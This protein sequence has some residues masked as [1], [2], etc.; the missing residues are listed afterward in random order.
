MSEARKFTDEQLGLIKRNAC[1]PGNRDATPDEFNLFMDRV[2]STGLNPLT[3]QIYAVFRWSNKERIDKMSIQTGIDGFRLIAERT[4]R[5]IGQSGPY[6]C[7]EDG[8]CREIWPKGQK[9]PVASKVVV[10]KLLGGV[11]GE[12]S[13]V[14]HWGEYAVTGS[15][16]KFW[17]SKPALLLSK[18]A[19]ALALRK[20]FPAEMS[21]LYIAEEMGDESVAPVDLSDRQQDLDRATDKQLPKL[22]GLITREKP[23]T[24]TLKAKLHD[25]GAG[26]L[27]PEKSGW[28]KQLTVR[29]AW[30][31]IKSL[32][33]PFQ[34]PGTTDIPA[35]AGDATD[36]FPFPTPEEAKAV[37]AAST[38]G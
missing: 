38:E 36:A 35:D 37:L 21:G 13:A 16:G 17:E 34:Q 10:K 24:K 28:A 29:Q 27:D 30:E 33:V 32:S 20:A 5:Y 3:N 6:W 22:K 9:N 14:A 25:I 19:E 7:G 2:Y 8:E 12:T 15:A 26:D 4:G 18:C 31:R 23:P 11:V 1:K